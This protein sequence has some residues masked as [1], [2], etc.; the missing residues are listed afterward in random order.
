MI[1]PTNVNTGSK[2]HLKDYRGIYKKEDGTLY[3]RKRINTMGLQSTSCNMQKDAENLV[4]FSEIRNKFPNDVCKK[5]E[6]RFIELMAER[7]LLAF[8]IKN[9]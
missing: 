8:K 4:R 3:A 6:K 1:N 9:S 2:V 5:C 7:K